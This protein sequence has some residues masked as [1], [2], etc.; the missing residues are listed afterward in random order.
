MFM[1]SRPQK[2]H[3]F[4]VMGTELQP[5]MGDGGTILRNAGLH[6]A[7]FK[8]EKRLT[9]FQVMRPAALSGLLN[10]T[11]DAIAMN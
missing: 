4:S 6:T 2:A 8:Q 5:L 11:L 1:N 7:N 3:V 10:P 9:I